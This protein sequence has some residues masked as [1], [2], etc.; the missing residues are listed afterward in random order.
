AEAARLRRER[1]E[2]RALLAEVLAARDGGAAVLARRV[3]ALEEER[4]VA[5]GQAVE[6]ALARSRAEAALKALR[7]AIE[8]APGWQGWLLRRARRRLDV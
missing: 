7:D 6:A 2:A 3:V 1:D 4:Q 5:R 8:K